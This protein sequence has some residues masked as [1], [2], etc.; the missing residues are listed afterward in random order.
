MLTSIL[1]NG[2]QILIGTQFMFNKILSTERIKW[3]RDDLFIPLLSGS[4]IAF[5]FY[6]VIPATSNTFVQVSWILFAGILVFSG[7]VLS[8]FHVRHSAVFFINYFKQKVTS[9]TKWDEIFLIY[10]RGP[11]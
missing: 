11:W 2:G 6:L 9:A 8:A 7:S 3:Y 5:I 1:L 10:A 4:I